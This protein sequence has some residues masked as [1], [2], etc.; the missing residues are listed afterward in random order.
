METAKL[1]EVLNSAY[2]HTSS[3]DAEEIYKSF[4]F[5]NDRIIVI[6]KN[7]S[8]EIPFESGIQIMVP[9]EETL[10]IIN[11][12]ESEKVIFHSKE[13]SLLIKTSGVQAQISSYEW[14]EEM[15]KALKMK[16]KWEKAPDHF[17]KG[18]KLC[19]FSASKD[20]TM[21]QFNAVY[22]DGNTI[23]STDNFRISLYD[24][25]ESM[26]NFLLPLP[27]AVIL[28]NQKTNYY[29]LE[30]NMVHFRNEDKSIIHCRIMD[31]KEYPDVSSFF[32]TKKKDK[33]TLPEELSK[34]ISLVSVLAEGDFL[35]D[36]KIKVSINKG[37]MKCRAEN[38]TGWIESNI[39]IDTDKN[40]SFL[41]NPYFF[42]E[43]LKLSSEVFTDGRKIIF[44][45]KNF[46]HLMML[47][48]EEK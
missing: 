20:I 30:E 22:I 45:M 38:E 13:N 7:Y 15:I 41:I 42:M 37:I 28:S 11:G 10:K 19:I 27:S 35:L 4:I 34:T 21:E 5:D 40:I 16:A 47:L 29:F 25:K 18:V 8:L 43:I 1:K 6:N 17:N 33:F 48:E 39:K 24:M 31:C 3:R 14:N 9:S 2:K 12:I 36:K 46:S 32:E 44:T 26:K 23:Q